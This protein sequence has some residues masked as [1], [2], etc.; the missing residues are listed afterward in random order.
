MQTPFTEANAVDL[1]VLAKQVRFLDRCG[2]QGMVWPQLA[3]SIRCLTK[4][5]RG[6]GARWRRLA[7]ATGDRDRGTGGR[8]PRR[9]ITR[10]MRPVFTRMC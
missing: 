6:S 10:G 8:R 5:G 1:P 2:V 7:S 4:S 3:S 9:S